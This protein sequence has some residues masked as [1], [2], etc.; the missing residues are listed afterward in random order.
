MRAADPGTVDWKA[1]AFCV[2]EQM[3]RVLRRREVFAKNSSKWG[4][5]RARLLGG[6][7]WEQ[8]KPS[9][10]ALLGLPA[11]AGE[12]LAARAALLDGT[13]RE[14]AARVPANSQIVSAARGRLR[15]P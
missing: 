1:Y 5:P 10:L 11:G 9:V 2:L 8:A 3:H 14:V 6:D 12:H 13:Y 15:R 4:D 7:A